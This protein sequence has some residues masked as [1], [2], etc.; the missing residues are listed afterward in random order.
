MEVRQQEIFLSIEDSQ[1]TENKENTGATQTSKMKTIPQLIDEVCPPLKLGQHN[2]DNSSEK[3]S[4]LAVRPTIMTT[5]SPV[6]GR[7][8][9]KLSKRRGLATLQQSASSKNSVVGALRN[10]A[11]FGGGLKQTKIE[12]FTE[13]SPTTERQQLKSR[14]TTQT[15]TQSATQSSAP[16][17]LMLGQFQVFDRHPSNFFLSKISQLFKSLTRHFFFNLRCYQASSILQH[18]IQPQLTLPPSPQLA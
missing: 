11:V 16:V 12:I 9:K 3:S 18:L 4:R 15:V 5:K 10:D 1:D 7:T 17:G 13:G 14:D 6:S 2:N 8:I